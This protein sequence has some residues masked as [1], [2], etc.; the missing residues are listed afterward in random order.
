MKHKVAKRIEIHHSEEPGERKLLIDG[1]EFEYNIESP[2][3]IRKS[4][5]LV[6]I[7]IVTEQVWEVNQ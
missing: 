2:G 3:P 7:T 1:Q 5:H 6:T 4:D